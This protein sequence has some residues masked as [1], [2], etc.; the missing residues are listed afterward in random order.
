MDSFEQE[1]EGHFSRELLVGIRRQKTLTRG[2]RTDRERA[3][4][5][6]AA[7]ATALL[8]HG[9]AEEYRR[10]VHLC[11][12]VAC[13]RDEVQPAVL[14]LAARMP[15]LSMRQLL[16]LAART[17]RQAP[18]APVEFEGVESEPDQGHCQ[19]FRVWT[20]G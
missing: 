4:E 13:A 9:E 20:G 12:E 15:K 10:Y 14:R 2:S 18:S 11:L 3:A 5:I 7:G 17:A 6:V 16:R 19:D 1:A 8:P